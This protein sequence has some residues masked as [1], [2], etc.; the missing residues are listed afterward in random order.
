MPFINKAISLLTQKRLTAIKAFGDRPQEIQEE[1]LKKLVSAASGTEYGKKYGFSF[2]SSSESFRKRVPV[3]S[4][5]DISDFILRTMNGEKNLLW[6]EDIKW[7]AKSSGTTNAKSKFIPVSPTLLEKCHFR[8]GRD[9]IAVFNA[10]YPDSEAFAGKT[11]ALGGS[12]EIH[13]SNKNCRFGDLSA[14]L[15]SNTPFWADRM[16]TPGAS[17]MLM[18]DWEEKIEK[19]CRNTINKDVRILAGVPSWFLSLINR[20]L[21]FTGKSDLHEV[22]PNMELFIHGGIGFSPYRA[23]Y[24][25]L[26][27]APK[28][29]Y[30][31]TYNASE[32]F[33]GLQD[34]PDDSSMLLMLDYGV[35]YEFLPVNEI[36]APGCNARKLEEIELG[37]NYAMLISTSG[38][39]WRYMIGDTVKFTSKNPY[40]FKITGRTKL[41]INAFG[42][43]LI[44]DNA[45]SGL[46]TACEKTGAS[47]FEFTAAPVF[48]DNK[49][50][51]AHEWIVEFSVPPED[52]E[53]FAD[54]LDKSLQELN[55]DY[56]AKRLSSLKR[57]V[58]HKARP[59][60]FN[61]W[62]KEK[63][64]LGG[65]H[66]IPR[67]W[68]DRTH[69]DE[70][71]K[72]NSQLMPSGPGI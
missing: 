32:G 46:K 70:I 3:V 1:V 33:F 11:L 50:R 15:I 37:V 31:E 9:T 69:I 51:G 25:R 65:Q 44:I 34:D 63:G 43:E 59:G 53:V 42:E 28:M 16:K 38:G 35:Y 56:E 39:L 10:L 27:P 67:L 23:E 45:L 68:N 54:I 24:R 21:E 62:L 2:I 14:I 40:K 36:H 7:F 8:G 60:L 49:N 57:L 30:M 17:T 64:M 12:S 61:A 72:M 6:P 52:I 58:I 13:K 20:I 66:K 4:Y 47:V 19:V 48:M 26:L 55:S 29:K 41:F 71:L 5:E 22:W 18:S